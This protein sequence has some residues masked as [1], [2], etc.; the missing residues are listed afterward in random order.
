MT[1]YVERLGAELAARGVGR[2]RR[3]RILA[4]IDD[5]LACDPGADLG[6]PGELARQF[7]DELGTSLARRAAF[8]A[9]CA[10]AVAGAG[11]AAAFVTQAGGRLARALGSGTSLADIG[12]G[13][14]VLAAQVAF[15]AGTLAALRAFRLRRAAAVPRS[16]AG[17]LLRRAGV[18]LA[19][20]AAVMVGLAL[21][22]LGLRG[23]IAGWWVTLALT[24]AAVGTAALVCAVPSVL[25][26]ARVMPSLEGSAGDLYDDLGPLVPSE[27]RGRPWRF[28]LVVAAAVA[29]LIALA[30]AIQS[31][32]FDGALRGA[33]DGAA[34]L[35]GYGVLGRYLGLRS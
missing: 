13:V 2:R 17:V 29:L 24:A 28:T 21:A 23:Y 32:G 26:A 4:E 14:M 34:C 27:L 31:D 7:A 19:A 15:V 18:G 1:S 3:T 8:T 33:A 12:A 16:E 9:F 22:A 35:A 25:S 30:G 11:F 20:G 10:L 6:A 5:H